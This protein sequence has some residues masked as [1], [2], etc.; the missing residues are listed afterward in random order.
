MS[1]HLVACCAYYVWSC[2]VVVIT[3]DFDFKIR[4]F[5][6]NPG[7]NPGMTFDRF[8]F[9]LFAFIILFCLV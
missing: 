3:P 2:S 7:S 5:S 4:T 6:G 8:L 1:T 9:E